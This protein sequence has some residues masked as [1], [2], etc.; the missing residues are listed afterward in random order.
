MDYYAWTVPFSDALADR[1]TAEASDA[2][3][4]LLL[5]QSTPEMAH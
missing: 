5:L 3:N 4:C 2:A 1:A